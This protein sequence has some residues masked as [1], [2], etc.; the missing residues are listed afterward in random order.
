MCEDVQLFF[1]KLQVQWTNKDVAVFWILTLVWTVSIEE[2]WSLVQ[3]SWKY[4]VV[5]TAVVVI[6]TIIRVHMGNDTSSNVMAFLEAL[7]LLW[8]MI[9]IREEDHNAQL[10]QQ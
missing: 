4:V 8:F 9:R 6:I 10:Y 5:V 2:I 1:Q 3:H 7:F